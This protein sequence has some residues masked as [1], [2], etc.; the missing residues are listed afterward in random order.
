MKKENFVA[1]ILPLIGGKENV[2]KVY[3][4]MTRFRL[5]LKDKEVIDL[6]KIETVDG[7]LGVQFVANELQIIIGPAVN[8]VYKYFI[9]YTGLEKQ[10]AIAENLENLSEEKKKITV[11]SVL[12]TALD[13][14]SGCM[15]PL[16]PLMVTIGAMNVLAIILGPTCLNLFAADS[17]WYKNFTNIG[18]AIMYFFPMLLAYTG[19]KY[20][21]SSTVITMTIAAFLLYPD[22][23]AIV[24]A[25][26]PYTFMG[27]SINLINYSRSVLPMLFIPWVQKYVEKFLHKYIP[28]MVKVIFV[29][30]LTVLIMLTLSLTMLGPIATLI[31]E[32]LKIAVQGLYEFCGP[33]ETAVHGSFSVLSTAFGFGR[34]IRLSAFFTF[35]ETGYDYTILPQTD[36]IQNFVAMGATTG[37]LIKTKKSSNRKLAVTCLVANAFGGVSEPSIF[38]IFMVN[39]VC[40]LATC[41][42]GAVSGLVRGLL[43]VCYY[44]V[45]SSSIFGVLA[46]LDPSGPSNLI[47]GIISCAVGFFVTMA[48]TIV[49]YRDKQIG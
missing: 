47:K 25:G 15:S 13:A 12:G 6:E 32:G 43:N 48:V 21:R 26:E 10:E 40:L 9:E 11:K 38:G 35:L 17:D 23:I 2:E 27:I 1:D 37:Y 33:L 42:G 24:E 3:H 19:S 49:L 45:A 39:R 36:V 22:F 4:C 8:S 5:I 34:P 7:V 46:F 30:A 16:V 41:I 18:M 20:H 44:Q 28:D 29:P 31:G 14:L